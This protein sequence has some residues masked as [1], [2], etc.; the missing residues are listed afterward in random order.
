MLSLFLPYKFKT[1]KIF[2]C[3][4]KDQLLFQWIGHLVMDKSVLKYN[5]NYPFKTAENYT[6]HIA[7][8]DTQVLGF[9]PV[10][11]RKSKCIINN[12]YIADDKSEVFSALLQHVIEMHQDF[13]I[14]AVAQIRHT[15]LFSL[16]G[17]KVILYWKKYVKLI[18][19]ETGKKS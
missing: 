6:W 11:Q 5:N 7:H 18:Y 10:E 15:E 19:A 4:G 8:D 17:F 13:P 2:V 16:H 14:E 1:M 9:I 12:Y 3:N